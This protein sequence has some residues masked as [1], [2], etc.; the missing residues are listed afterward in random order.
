M[1]KSMI[2]DVTDFGEHDVGRLQVAVHH[3]HAVRV[4]Q[5]GQALHTQRGRPIGRQRPIGDQLLERVATHELHDHQPLAVV[6]E[7]FVDG[8]DAGMAEPG[9]RDGFGA[10]AARDLG[11]VQFGVENLDGDFAVEGLVDGSVHRTHAA[12]SDAV[13]HTVFADV[14][15]NHFRVAR[16]RQA[17]NP[18]V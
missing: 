8:G 16:A 1:P 18:A 13:Q 5:R 6:L 7:E 4:R 14:L 12:A 11:V 9:H 3:A 2:F 17:G 15:P 10:E